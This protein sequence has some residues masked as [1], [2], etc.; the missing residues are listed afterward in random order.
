MLKIYL[1]LSVTMLIWGLNLPLVK[2]LLG[3]M[4]PVTMTAFRILLAGITVFTILTPL[5]LVR[6]PTNQEWLYI[7]GGALLNVVL[8]HYFMSVGLSR[9]TATNTGL[10]LGMGPVLTAIFTALLLRNNPSKI[11]WIGAAIGFAGIGSIVLA[12]GEGVSGLALGDAFIFFSI[13]AQVLSFMV[14]AKAARTLDPRLLTAYMFIVG[15]FFLIIVS[16]IQEPGQI[17]G[18]A[19]APPRFWIAFAASGMIGSAVGHML[20][21]YSVGKVGPAK[22]AI[23]MNLN[24]LFGL[25]GSAIFLGEII[26]GRHLIGFLFIIIGVILGSGAAEELWKRKQKHEPI[27]KEPG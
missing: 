23:F 25:I 13:L 3:F 27:Q 14:I 22:A 11:Q 21:N 6:R 19:T 10:I 9:T 26:T 1:L 12:G 15:S 4:D 17:E 2:Y 5:N 8:H 20:Y 18:F 24:T 16:M 7:L